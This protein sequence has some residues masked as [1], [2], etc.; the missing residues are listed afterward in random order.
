MVSDM[1]LHIKQ[2]D[3]LDFIKI[4]S[5]YIQLRSLDIYG[6]EIVDASTVREW[7]ATAMK[8]WVRSSGAN[9]TEHKIQVMIHC[10]GKCIASSSNG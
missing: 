5:F 4:A 1:K 10:W 7:V 6:D 2:M 9:L 3:V 8:K